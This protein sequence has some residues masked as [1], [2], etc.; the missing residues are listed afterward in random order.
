MS[1][2]VELLDAVWTLSDED[3]RHISDAKDITSCRYRIKDALSVAMRRVL[4]ND[5]CDPSSG[6]GLANPPLNNDT[7]QWRR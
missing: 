7:T 5:R 6:D 3:L 1:E 2:R 4:E